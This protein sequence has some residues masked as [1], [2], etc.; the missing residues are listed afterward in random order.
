MEGRKRYVTTWRNKWLTAEAKSIEEMI[1]ML[2]SAADNLDQMRRD[3][4]VLDDDGGVSD[5][6]ARLV[7][8]DPSVA[9]KYGLV[10][11]S[12]YWEGIDQHEDQTPDVGP[13]NA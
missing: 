5:D 10:D 11:E 13:A 8:M 7:S 4:V 2:R 9:A 12:E 6:H 3:G 1:E